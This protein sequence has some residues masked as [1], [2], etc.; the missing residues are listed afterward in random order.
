MF[1]RLSYME[2]TDYTFTDILHTAV[3]ICI[4]FNYFMTALK[5]RSLAKISLCF[6]TPA[7]NNQ[8]P[9]SLCSEGDVSP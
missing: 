2:N 1:V 9:E 5:L 4:G 8:E 3:S 6:D 7:G